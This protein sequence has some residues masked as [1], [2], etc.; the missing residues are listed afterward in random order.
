MIRIQ[1]EVRKT[2]RELDSHYY[3]LE[4]ILNE[5]GESMSPKELRQL[6]NEMKKYGWFMGGP[7]IDR[8]PEFPLHFS[9][10]TLLL[11]TVPSIMD[12]CIHHIHQIMQL[13]R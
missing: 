13:W 3:E 5:N 11:L 1:N 4:R 7:F 10:L 12:W 9:L 6:H 2:K 8:Y